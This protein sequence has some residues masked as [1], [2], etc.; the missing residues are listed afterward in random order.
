MKNKKES[1]PL[2]RCPEEVVGQWK[3]YDVIL[4]SHEPVADAT[5]FSQDFDKFSGWF[6]AV[7]ADWTYG[8]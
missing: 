8:G 7:L 2:V 3:G 1:R 5:V 4:K 6:K